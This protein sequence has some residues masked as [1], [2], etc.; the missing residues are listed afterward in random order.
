MLYVYLEPV[1]AVIIAAVVLGEVL[2][3]KQAVGA[4]LA[5]VGVGLASTQEL[6]EL[7]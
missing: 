5:F 3:P 2:R 6:V 4:L 1:S 7:A